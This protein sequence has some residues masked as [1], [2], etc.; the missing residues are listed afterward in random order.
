[1]TAHRCVF[2]D[3]PVTGQTV[4][5]AGGAGAVSYYAIQFAK[6]GG[7]QVFTTVSSAAKADV[8]RAA[9]ADHA[10]NYRS[11]DV[12]ARIQ[13]LTHGQGVDRV[14]EVAFGANLLQNARLLK[15]NGA[16]AAYASDAVPEPSIPYRL[17]SS[18]NATLHCVL[19]YVMS[20]AAHQAAIADITTCLESG[21]IGHPALHHF[22]L[23]DIVAA[24]EGVESGQVIGKALIDIA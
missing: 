10:I 12:V 3:G 23:T 21:R 5:V 13:D 18:K 20:P 7:A 6:W 8:A 2:A 15:A 9:G 22:P 19:V 16:I 1:M 14:V 24:H 17:L 4:L 11:E